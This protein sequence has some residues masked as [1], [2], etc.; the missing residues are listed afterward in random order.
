MSGNESGR[1]HDNVGREADRDPLAWAAEVIADGE[2]PEDRVSVPLTLDSPAIPSSS[3][4]HL[5][6]PAEMYTIMRL[7]PNSMPVPDD[8]DEW[9]AAFGRVISDRHLPGGDEKTST[10]QHQEQQR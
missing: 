1:E 6:S 4:A 8:M 9:I 5:E 7:V 10:F 3:L 2:N